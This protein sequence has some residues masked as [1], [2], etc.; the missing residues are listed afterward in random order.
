V[1]VFLEELTNADHFGI[2]PQKAV[3]SDQYIRAKVVKVVQLVIEITRLKDWT[4]CEL[5]STSSKV[6]GLV[7]ARSMLTSKN[8]A[9]VWDASLTS[10]GERSMCY[11]S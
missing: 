5:V 1:A 6:D 8:L 9:D 11:A 4:A 7:S 3:D 10:L 2:L